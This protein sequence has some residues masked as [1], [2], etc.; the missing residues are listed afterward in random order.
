MNLVNDPW[1][2]VRTASGRERVISPLDLV[3]EDP[4]VDIAAIRPDFGAAIVQL[5]IGMVQW[6]VPPSASDWREVASGRRLPDLARWRELAPCF[7][8]DT[9]ARRFMQ[10]MALGEAGDEEDDVSALLLDAP[11]G[12]TTR[13][14]ADLFVKRSPGMCLSLSLAAQALLT[15][16]TNAPSGGKGHRTSLRGGGPLTMLLWPARIGG[17]AVPLWRKLW[18]NTIVIEEDPEPRPEVIFPWMAD[19]LTS[20]EG[21]DVHAQLSPRS[22][23]R[24]ELTLLCYFA[25]PRR[26]RLRFSEERCCTLSGER[27]PCAVG[28]LARN[29]GANYRS[30]LF[31]HPLSPYYRDKNGA[32]LPRH[33]G[34]TGFTYADWV[35]AQ[36]EDDA[37]ARPAVLSTDRLGLA[38]ARELP[39]DAVW[40]FGFAFDNMKCLA[41]HETRFRYLAIED[42][43]RAAGVLA[44]A[45]HWIGAVKS[46]RDLLTRLLRQAWGADKPSGTSVAERELYAAT[47]SDFYDLLVERAALV[48]DSGEVIVAA[49]RRMRTQ[50]KGRLVRAAMD[51][52]RRHAERG[53]AAEMSLQALKRTSRAHAELA[54]AVHFG[55]DKVL[56]LAPADEKRGRTGSKRRTEA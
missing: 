17:E 39:P 53:D 43:E 42:S 40:A 51:V 34:P 56:G 30:E 13:N 7:E 10:D 24:L 54:R 47:E 55:L 20:E 23:T 2:P 4:V 16:Q 37:S 27:G 25:T 44:E 33:L 41:W 48:T 15:L 14:N 9:G 52:F 49:H 1:I 21:K 12:N 32:W 29:L 35:T 36:A 5:L 46:V 22:P 11:G 31:R 8:F 50:W 26:I 45:Q 28:M 6:L 18:L 38:L 19:S 3:G